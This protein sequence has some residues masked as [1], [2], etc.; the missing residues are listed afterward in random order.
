MQVICLNNDPRQPIL[1][2]NLQNH[3]GGFSSAFELMSTD[4]P[5][6]ISGLATDGAPFLSSAAINVAPQDP[7]ITPMPHKQQ[8]RDSVSASLPIPGSSREADTREVREFWKQYMSAPLTRPPDSALN[9]AAQPGLFPN[10][11]ISGSVPP[12]HATTSK[13]S[14]DQCIQSSFP[15]L[16]YN[17]CG[18]YCLT[19]YRHFFSH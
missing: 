1:H 6:V 14:C 3:E 9:T 4:D 16:G 8:D 18:Q 10:Q 13:Q 2:P 12:S 17:P 15:C 19:K 7:N 5:N 11:Q